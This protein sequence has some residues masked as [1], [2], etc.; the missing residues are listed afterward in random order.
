MN[1]HPIGDLAQSLMTRRHGAALQ[2]RLGQLT[3][4]LST[5]RTADI[6]QHLKGSIG[7]LADLENQLALNTAHRSAS[8]EASVQATAMQAALD[9]VQTQLRDMSAVALLVTGGAGEPGLASVA[10]AARGGLDAMVSALNGEVAGRPVFGGT[11]LDRAPLM[12]ADDILNAA[13]AAVSA[14]T[15]AAGAVAALDTFFDAPGGAFDALVYRGGTEDTAPV[16]LGGGE[17]V[18]LAIRADDPVLR[19]AIKGAVMAALAGDGALTL[20]D[21]DRLS[22]LRTASDGMLSQVDGLTGIRADLGFAEDR[23]GQSMSRLAAE[24]T[25][26]EMVRNETLAVDM[27][28]TASAL[29]EVQTQLET[30]YTLTART[31]RLNLVNFL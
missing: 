26:L 16:R 28:E 8:T 29:E 15:D 17:S 19:G 10:R 14:A 11:A 2:S 18:Q 13:R 3:Q 20:A 1:F 22:L 9:H 4:E 24:R 31:S 5:G 27:F 21:G 25:S 7:P 12:G 30:I 6:R 23:I